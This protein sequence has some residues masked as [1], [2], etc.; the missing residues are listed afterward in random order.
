MM[1]VQV[2]INNKY[3]GNN[4]NNNNNSNIVINCINNNAILN[5]TE[6]RDIH[7]KN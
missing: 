7:S 3:N 4:I 1:N 2:F 5:N 6:Q